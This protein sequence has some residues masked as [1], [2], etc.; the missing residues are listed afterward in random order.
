M[1]PNKPEGPLSP[2][3]M[4]LG[5]FCI[6]GKL[7]LW[8]FHGYFQIKLA[9]L[10]QGPF[11]EN[12]H[13]S[14]I[15]KFDMQANWLPAHLDPSL[16]L[17]SLWQLNLE[18]R[19]AS[20][21]AQYVCYYMVTSVVIKREIGFSQGTRRSPADSNSACQDYIL[22]NIF[23]VWMMWALSNLKWSFLCSFTVTQNSFALDIHYH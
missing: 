6:E 1:H 13:F 15:L 10:A 11:L 20:H 21:S 22:E 23:W 2:T 16:E 17:H 9:L 12:P 19:T 7:G 14:P 4:D 18:S 5:N 3:L 8:T